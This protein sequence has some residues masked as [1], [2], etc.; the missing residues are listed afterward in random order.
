LCDYSSKNEK[1]LKQH[2][3]KNHKEIKLDLTIEEDCVECNLLKP[4]VEALEK[5]V[6]KIEEKLEL[7]EM[8]KYTNNT[9]TTV[10]SEYLEKN[11]NS[12]FIRDFDMFD[13]LAEKLIKT[14][15]IEAR[16]DECDYVGRNA[17]RVIKHKEVK[18]VHKCDIC[19][20][21]FEYIGDAEIKR[22]KNLVHH[23]AENIL[24]EKE[25]EELT[26]S[27]QDNIRFGPDTPRK[28]DF[29]KRYKL[30]KR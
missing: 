24:T 5:Y 13:C 4:K 27:D 20:D 14:K 28:E 7:K 17:A 19:G 10:Q 9:A 2:I 25:F 3:R 29:M 30:R 8:E 22:H 26:V 6:L 12:E 18:H 23:C 15:S 1:K 16:C 21:E 11:Y